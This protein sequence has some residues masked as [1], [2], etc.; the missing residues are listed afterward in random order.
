VLAVLGLLPVHAGTE[1]VV[2]P[3][4]QY[5]VRVDYADSPEGIRFHSAILIDKRT[6]RAIQTL[7]TRDFDKIS[8]QWS[9]DSVLV[10]VYCVEMRSG[11]TDVYRIADSKPQ[12]LEMPELALP[13]KGDLKNPSYP[14]FD[15]RK[16]TKWNSPDRLVL[17]CTGKVQPLAMGKPGF[18]FLP[19]WI[20]YDYQVEVQFSRGHGG[21]VKS[22][23][24][25]SLEH[26]TDKG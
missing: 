11:W 23:K 1:Q 19:E 8:V 18:Q 7:T 6:D 15:Y 22:M 5:S 17:N 9:P 26:E 20:Q 24:K 21:K 10:A 3:N 13:T 14:R 2:S 12:K 4:R 16:P 25:I